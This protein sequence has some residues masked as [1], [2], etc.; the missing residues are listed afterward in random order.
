MAGEVVGA[1][2]HLLSSAVLVIPCAGH[3]SGEANFLS[4]QLSSRSYTFYTGAALYRAGGKVL[5]T[6]EQH[7]RPRGNTR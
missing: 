5:E 7:A 1:E 2:A 3:S 6:K 4:S